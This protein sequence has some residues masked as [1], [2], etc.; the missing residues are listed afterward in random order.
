MKPEDFIL[1]PRVTR[2]AALRT[3]AATPILLM[4]APALAADPAG[5][6]GY[7]VLLAPN[8]DGTYRKSYF[9][10]QQSGQTLT[11]K[12]MFGNRDL[13]ISNGSVQ[14]GKVRF[15]VV[16]HYRTETR[17]INYTG[18]VNGEKIDMKVAFQGRSPRT[19]TAQRTTREATLP[20]KPLPLPEL[21]DLPDN[22]LV[23]TPPMGWN[24]WNKFAGR[25]DDQ[26]VRSVADAM[27]A[28][29]MSKVGYEYINID[30]TW[31]GGRDSKGRITGNKKFPDMKALADYVHSK[32]LKIGIYSSPGPLT[33]AGYEASF[34]HEE[35]DAKTYAEWGFDYLKYD[36]CSAGNIYKDT[37]MRPVYQKM[38]EALLNCGRPIVYSL[39]QYGRDDVWGWGAKVSGNLWRTTG[40]INDH[41]ERMDDIGF[42]QFAIQHYVRPGH[43]NDPDMLE[44]GNGGM[45]SDEY[46]THMS[47][48]CLLAAPLLAG[49][50]LSSMTEDTK[51]ILMN[52]EVIAIDQDPA[53]QP[54][55][56]VTYVG[57][58]MVAYRKLHDGSTAV[59]FFNRT[60]KEDE[61]GVE[62]SAVGIEGK[63]LQ[64][65]DL[66]KHD[67]TEVSG[68]HYS[69]KVP[70]HGVV[71]LKVTEKM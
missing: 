65:R 41:W 8:G 33:C 14:N 59:A 6:S 66:W 68:H 27:V 63:T 47:L 17:R 36:W 70:A 52:R 19:G 54:A 69:T 13:P 49:N 58:L 30:D 57:K 22:G 44:I 28:S 38:G 21:R 62:W 64:A 37:D 35:Q 46:R 20:P 9:Y 55:Q 23:R 7:W 29:G 31:Q 51:S 2:R 18:Q 61:I 53:A 67:T 40:D 48:W 56:L 10:L 24:S 25:V 60:E 16:I 71:M 34:G 4:G 42:R 50:D 15:E 39:C 32:G 1:G 11:G 12:V 26:I 3:L 5:L 45:N 43:W